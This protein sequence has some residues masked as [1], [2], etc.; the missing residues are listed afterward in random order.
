LRGEVAPFVCLNQIRFDELALKSNTGEICLT[1]IV[2][3]V[4]GPSDPFK[5]FLSHSGAL[6]GRAVQAP[7]NERAVCFHLNEQA[8]GDVG[9]SIHFV[10]KI[11]RHFRDLRRDNCR[12]RSAT[13]CGS[14]FRPSA[15]RAETFAIVR[16]QSS[17][18]SVSILVG[19]FCFIRCKLFNY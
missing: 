10:W 9:R 6:R 14:G 16:M 2:P 3:L 17:C 7:E 1:Q 5:S 8:T 19:L 12:K 18:R 4:R 13:R 11:D 15:G